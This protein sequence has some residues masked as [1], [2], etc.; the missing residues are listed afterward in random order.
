[1]AEEQV[2]ARRAT[3]IDFESLKQDPPEP[4]LLGVLTMEP[5]H[6][7]QLVLD[8]VLSGAAKAK[9]H[10]RAVL[11]PQEIEELTEKAARGPEIV[12]WSLFERTVIEQAELSVDLK[13]S[14]R[15]SIRQRT[16]R[17]E[18]EDQVYQS[19]NF[20]RM[21]VVSSADDVRLQSSHSTLTFCA[22]S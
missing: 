12:G 11:L 2:D 15:G 22:P 17:H 6:F 9:A 13:Q 7:E 1:M 19:L 4:G 3:C 10:C 14:V 18:V 20:R 5:V 21:I 16:D 8:P